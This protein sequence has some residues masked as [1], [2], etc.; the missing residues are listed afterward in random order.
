MPSN[1]SEVQYELFED[2]RAIK[3]MDKNAADENLIRGYITNNNS[4]N[5]IFNNYL[6]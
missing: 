6:S 5:I 2:K 3:F 4:N 1:S